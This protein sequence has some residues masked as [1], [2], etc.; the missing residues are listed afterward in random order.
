MRASAFAALEAAFQCRPGEIAMS[1]VAAT[2]GAFSQCSC[3]RNLATPNFVGES[4][5]TSPMVMTC[6]K[7]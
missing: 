3:A 4:T 5:H 1:S 7:P 6:S 2:T